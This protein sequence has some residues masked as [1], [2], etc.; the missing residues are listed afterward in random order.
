MYD[1]FDDLDKSDIS[2][3]KNVDTPASSSSGYPN[4]N[5]GGG[6]NYGNNNGGNNY[7]RNN[8]GGGNYNRQ[9][10]GGGGNRNFQRKEE[11]VE[12]PYVPVAIYVDRDFSP[13]IKNKIFSFA[14]KLI[15]RKITV[16]Y[17]ADD[18]EFHERLSSLSDKYTEAYIPWKNFN[19]IE[20]KHYWNT[21]TSKHLAQQHFGAWDKIPDSVKALLARNVRMI[22]GDK[23]NSVSLCLI[24]WSADG[25]ARASEVTKDTG[26]A[27]FIIKLAGSYG[28]PILNVQKEN[29]GNLLERIFGI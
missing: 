7:N 6:N 13:E 10:A 1:D 12:E 15:N 28:F 5:N 19:E 26:R 17:N 3:L 24:T 21:D 23:N 11:V 14:S 20:S 16:R 9:G 25:A 22:F 8:N 18:K 2:D 27:S 4:R 29:T